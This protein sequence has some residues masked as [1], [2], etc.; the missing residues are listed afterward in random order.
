VSRGKNKLLD[1]SLSSRDFFAELVEEALRKRKVKTSPLVQTYLTELLQVYVSSGHPAPNSTLAE[2]LMR[3]QQ[4][5]RTVRVELL[6][7]LG[8]TSLYIS[9]FFGDSL[10]RKIVDIDYYASMGGM[11]YGSLSKEVDNTQ[12]AEIFEEFSERF[13]DF[14]DVLTY[15]SQ[16]T[17]VQTN[18][19]VL[20]LYDRYLSTGSELAR[21]Q[22]T[23]LGVLNP[24]D[25]K[26]IAQ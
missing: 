21:E 13:L 20:R 24:V 10:K 16:I 4:A 15:V 3:A 25:R 9:G 8:D 22:L 14:V 5:E 1:L 6:R 19:D 26:K 11:A 17:S 18:Q 23:E 7:K 12:Q 2:M